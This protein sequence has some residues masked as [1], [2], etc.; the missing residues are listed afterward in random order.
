MMPEMD[1]VEAV[2]II[3]E[4]IGTKYAENVPIIAL[5]ANAIAGNEEMFLNKGFQAFI[6]KPIEIDRLDSII[7]QW[8]R[9]EKLDAELPDIT[10]AHTETLQAQATPSKIMT[11]NIDGVNLKEGLTRFSDD[12]ESYLSVLRSYTDNTRPLLD[13]IKRVTLDNLNDYAITVHGIK[14]SSYGICAQT[15][16]EKAEALEH[17]SKNGDID[18]VNNNNQE[19]I[20]TVEKLLKDLEDMLGKIEAKTSKLKKEKPDKVI[21]ANLLE[22]CRNY[23]MDT[24]D[25]AMAELAVYEYETDG[26]LVPWLRENIET[27]NLTQIIERLSMM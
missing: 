18:F 13:K 24:V 20:V 5:T 14:G 6:S 23:D 2:R 21:L 4:E 1:G 27:M 15:A 22:A 7:R 11:F 3:R 8:V 17:A 16:G 12:E 19:F 25:E 9:D 10:A 26:E